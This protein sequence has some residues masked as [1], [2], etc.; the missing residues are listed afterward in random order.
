MSEPAPPAQA[1]VTPT[2][3]IRAVASR[4]ARRLRDA[5][6]A[7]D[8]ARRELLADLGTRLAALASDFGGEQA[9]AVRALIL[10]LAEDRLAGVTGQ[11]LAGLW[12]RVLALL[13]ALA[14][15]QG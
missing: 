3:G 6:D 13:D 4:E 10:E 2:P 8:F 7:P 14:G 12:D 1:P 15:K 11:A 9:Q 5:A